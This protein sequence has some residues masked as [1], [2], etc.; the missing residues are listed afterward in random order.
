LPETIAGLKQKV[1]KEFNPHEI[2]DI[3]EDICKVPQGFGNGY[4]Q[5][6]MK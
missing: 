5:V 6:H 4:P 2:K 3:M 1:E